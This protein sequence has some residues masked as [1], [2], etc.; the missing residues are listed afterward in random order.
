MQPA[1]RP[2]RRSMRRSASRRGPAPLA[3]PASVRFGPSGAGG[4]VVDYRLWLGSG[5]ASIGIGL[6]MPTMAQEQWINGPWRVAG[7]NASSMMVGVRYQLSARS[8]LYVDTASW[9][10]GELPERDVRLGFEFKSA[11]SMCSAWRA[12]P[13]SACNGVRIRRFRCA[14]AAAASPWR[15][16]RSSTETPPRRS[17]ATCGCAAGRAVVAAGCRSRACRCAGAGRPASGRTG[18]PSPAA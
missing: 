17:F 2:L 14:C 9:S 6:A 3:A 11:P 7:S 12:A 13:C 10:D 4:E 1:N 18:R 8:R 15:C 5:R 16:A